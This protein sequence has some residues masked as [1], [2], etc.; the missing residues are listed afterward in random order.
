M[1][2]RDS[3]N[4]YV[5]RY[6]ELGQVE[7]I[8]DG[9]LVIDPEVW[10]GVVSTFREMY[11]LGY[12]VNREDD[13]SA[14][15]LG[16]NLAFYEAGTWTNATLMQVEGLNYDCIMMPV[17]SP[18]T[19]LCRAGTHTWMQP[20][21]EDRTEETDLAV[22][23]FVNWMGAHSLPWATEA[24]QVPLYK[25][26]TETE[27][28]KACKQT[29]LADAGISENIKIFQYYYWSTF[30]SAV[31]HAGADA[32]YDESIDVNSVGAAIQQEVDDA[33]AAGV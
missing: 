30:T 4:S 10:G 19:A 16:G 12:M 5:A 6:E 26:V 18:E 22:A 29:F 32:I 11:T 7:L 2:I 17:F 9:N 20:E 33:I 14:M 28:F 15:F 27:E 8:Q 1:C 31:D 13:A 23:T 3:F 25:A 24:G 21:N